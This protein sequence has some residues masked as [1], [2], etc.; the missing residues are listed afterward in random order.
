MFETL[1]VDFAA[2]AGDRTLEKG[3]LRILLRV[4]TPV[5]LCYRYSRW[6]MS[7]RVPVV[8]HLLMIAAL[9]WQRFNQI[10]MG[11]FIS[12]DADIGPGLVVHTPCQIFVAPTKIGEN[13]TLSIGIS[14]M[15]AAEALGTTC[16]SERAV[17]L[18]VRSKLAATLLSPP[19]AW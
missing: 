4:E 7:L 10:V 1:R 11:V 18:W 15:L 14:S 12:P 5:V 9:I 17:K 19:T 2:A 6:V 16:T 8:R 3:F 13:C